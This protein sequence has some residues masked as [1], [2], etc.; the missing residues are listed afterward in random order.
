LAFSS[1][2][3]QVHNSLKN[4]FDTPAA[5]EYLIDIVSKGNVY[6]TGN[7]EKKYLLL[8][9]IK[10]YV[11]EILSIF[12]IDMEDSGTSSSA[13]ALSPEQIA[14]PFAKVI[15]DFRNKIRLGVKNKK[16]LDIF[17]DFAMIFG[18]MQCPN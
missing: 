16:D 13:S 14:R 11:L 18:K 1:A 8:A 3:Q 15:F 6:L 9:K 12:G 10:E 17:S 7:N 4:N 2:K 5:V